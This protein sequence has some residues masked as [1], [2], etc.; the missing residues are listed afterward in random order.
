MKFRTFFGDYNLVQV[1][2]GGGLLTPPTP[3]E[4]EIRCKRLKSGEIAYGKLIESEPEQSGKPRI[5][6]VKEVVLRLLE[7]LNQE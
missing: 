4:L 7:N 3:E 1:C 2:G 5:P 6:V